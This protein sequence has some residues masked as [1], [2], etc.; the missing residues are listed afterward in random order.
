MLN[1][2]RNLSTDAQAVVHFGLAEIWRILRKIVTFVAYNQDT[3][4][5]K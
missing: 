3:Y 5:S 1:W 4:N 2:R